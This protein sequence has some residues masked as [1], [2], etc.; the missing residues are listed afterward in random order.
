MTIS[1][2]NKHLALL[3][4]AQA[5]IIGRMKLLQTNIRLTKI[6][7]TTVILLATIATPSLALAATHNFNVLD[8]SSQTGMLVSLT[9]HSGV[10]EPATTKN[11]P[12]L[13]GVIG[14]NDKDPAPPSG[15]VSVKSDE[16][17][18]A[19]VSTL[20]GNIKVGDRITAS[21]IVGVGAKMQGTGWVVGIAQS[22]LDSKTTG[23]AS[24]FVVDSKGAK[25]QVY[26]THIPVLVKVA[27]YNAPGSVLQKTSDL[28]PQQLQNLA[29]NAAGKHV[30]ALALVLST[31][32][33]IIGLVLSGLVITSSVRG[34]FLA[35]SRQ[36]LAKRVI[37]REELQS[38]AMSAL[39]LI[40]VL[41]GAFALLRIL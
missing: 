30:S 39:I 15:Q 19:L 8:N 31:L 28:V 29:N 5:A 1:S 40:V 9:Q 25:H 16:Q 4:K 11:T 36:P 3:L 17:A 23:A 2:P 41:V 38:F 27:Y 13:I 14:A 37:L 22:S 18:E 33:L 32:L 21:S 24:S 6:T 34:G 12:R 20:E 10:V 7:L 26:V 35:I